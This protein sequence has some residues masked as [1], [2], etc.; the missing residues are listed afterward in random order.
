MTQ[1]VIHGRMMKFQALLFQ[2]ARHGVAQVLGTLLFTGGVGVGLSLL[3]APDTFLTYA[4]LR[5][6]F[7]FAS[8]AAWG[9]AFVV[10]SVALIVSVYV[11]PAYAQLPA[12]ILGGVFITFGLL[13]LLSS[14]ALIVWAFIALG[15][16]SIFTQ[17]ICWAEEKRETVHSHQPH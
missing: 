16:I 14:P 12:L 3:L 8:P 2:A 11:E 13:T 6:N 4:S 17:I 1:L 9:A 10:A 15:W 5:E 7:T